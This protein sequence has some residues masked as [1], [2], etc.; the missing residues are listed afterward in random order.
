MKTISKR[1]LKA[2]LAMLLVVIMLLSSTITGFAAAVDKAQ[3]KESQ[4]FVAGEYVYFK[5]DMSDF[6]INIYAY[7]FSYV[8]FGNKKFI[9][10]N[11]NYWDAHIRDDQFAPNWQLTVYQPTKTHPNMNGGIMYQIF[12]DRFYNSGKVTNLPQDRIYRSWGELP[13]YDDSTICSDFFGGD[14][15]G[16][17][18][19]LPYL[20]SLNISVLYLNPIWESQSNHRYN[21][22]SYENVDP[23]LGTMNDLKLLIDKAHSM[24]MIIILDTVLNHTGSDSIYF[25]R[26]NRYNS[27]GAYNSKNSSFR[28]WY[29][30]H[31]DNINSY[32]S[33][34]GFDTLP[35]INQNITNKNIIKVTLFSLINTIINTSKKL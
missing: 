23:V 31:D 34:W 2:S 6:E 24:G 5:T 4:T 3:T 28:D 1:F 10:R 18:E 32:E 12:P 11:D 9:K 15:N 26:Y 33:W 7:Y 21:T 30:F 13:Y 19:K 8:S 14:L 22:G 35:K 25:N 29:F 17:I 16:I 27:I 20:K